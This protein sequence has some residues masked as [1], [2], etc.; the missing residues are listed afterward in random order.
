VA[1]ELRQQTI[2]IDIVFD[3]PSTDHGGGREQDLADVLFLLRT[4][5]IEWDKLVG[6]FE[7][8]LPHMGEHS[9]KQDP[10]EFEQNFKA[11][12]TMWRVIRDSSS[13]EE[14]SG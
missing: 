13:K 8:I 11:L 14:Q 7:E 10:V 2:D 5:R 6:Y 1:K 3:V 12:E 4:G 9:L